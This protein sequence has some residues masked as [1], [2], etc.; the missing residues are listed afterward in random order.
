M[1]FKFCVPNIRTL[2]L[3]E[4]VCEHPWLSKK[5]RGAQEKDLGS[6]DLKSFAGI[7]MK[8]TALYM[9]KFVSKNADAY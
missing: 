7:R 4:Q 6:T 9:V 2:Y 8:R 3:H 1:H 5:K